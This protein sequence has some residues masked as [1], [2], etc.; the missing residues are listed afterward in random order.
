MAKVVFSVVAVVVCLAGCAHRSNQTGPPADKFE[1]F[2]LEHFPTPA[3]TDQ[4]EAWARAAQDQL[5]KEAGRG[6]EGTVDISA[7]CG[8][9][10]GGDSGGGGSAG[11]GPVT[12]DIEGPYKAAKLRVKIIIPQ[13]P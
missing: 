6:L 12:P 9:V 1:A 2:L 7:A 13:G 11:G 5:A 8:C 10:E 4:D 3:V